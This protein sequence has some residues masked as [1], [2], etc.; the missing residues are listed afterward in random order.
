MK[1][2]DSEHIKALRHD[3]RAHAQ[4]LRVEPAAAARME[5]IFE[6]VLEDLSLL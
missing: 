4:T 6:E 3:L 5:E 1:I 2:G